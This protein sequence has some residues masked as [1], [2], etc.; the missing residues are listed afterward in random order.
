MKICKQCGNQF[1]TRVVLESGEVKNLG[2][3]KF[4]LTCSPWGFHNTAV[5]PPTITNNIDTKCCSK[6]GKEKSKSKSEFYVRRGKTLRPVC[7]ECHNEYDKTKGLA[8]KLAAVEY[9]G[10]KCSV[11]GYCKYT[12]ALDFHHLDPKQKDFNISKNL[13]SKPSIESIKEEL[14]KCILLCA[15][16][17]R[18]LHGEEG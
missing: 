10:G 5:I 17:H 15:N 18:E 12:G 8:L 13:H 7:K 11:C 16:C 2:S 4:C 6:C 9:K 1:K 14:D 3:R